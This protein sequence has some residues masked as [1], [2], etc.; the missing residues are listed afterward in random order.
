MGAALVNVGRGPQLILGDLVAALDSGHLSGAMLDVFETEPLPPN[1]PVWTHPKIIV[2]PHLAS[3]AS[4][5]ARVRYV[6]DAIAAFE[7]GETPPNLFDP[8]RGY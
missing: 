1:D 5:P 3:M 4:R 2:T 6:A 8:V 7:R